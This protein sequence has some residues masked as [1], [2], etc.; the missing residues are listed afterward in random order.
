[1]PRSM[2]GA[3]RRRARLRV[4]FLRLTALRRRPG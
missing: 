4:A 3:R 1:V 2:H